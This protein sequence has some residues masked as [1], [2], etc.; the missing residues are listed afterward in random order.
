MFFPR[1]AVESLDTSSNW[2]AVESLDMISNSSDSLP[3]LEHRG[4]DFS[5]QLLHDRPVLDAEEPE[6]AVPAN[7][8]I[9]PVHVVIPI[10]IAERTASP[11]PRGS[12]GQESDNDFSLS[13]ESTEAMAWTAAEVAPAGLVHGATGRLYTIEPEEATEASFEWTDKLI[14]FLCNVLG[15][16]FNRETGRINVADSEEST[17]ASIDASSIPEA[18]FEVVNGTTGHLD[19]VEPEEATEGVPF[20]RAGIT[21]R[22]NYAEFEETRLIRIMTGYLPEGPDRDIRSL[23]VRSRPILSMID[24]AV[25]GGRGSPPDG[26]WETVSASV[27]SLAIDELGA[28]E[29]DQL[30]IVEGGSRVTDRDVLAGNSYRNHSGTKICANLV[31]E[32][33]PEHDSFGRSLGTHDKTEKSR[34]HREIIRDIL[35]AGGRFLERIDEDIPI[36]EHPSGFDWR[37]VPLKKVKE[38]VSSK[39]RCLNRGQS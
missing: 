15:V 4:R 1:R 22:L 18:R 28:I 17:E 19:T 38:R 5:E 14:A 6:E 9:L 25:G 21:D 23:I 10:P 39:I 3:E 7:I 16:P 35:I 2:S 12:E 36:G 34:I 26:N 11:R 27:G 31:R 24:R 33:K 29:N 32:R 13:E 8:A 37:F 20:P 30:G